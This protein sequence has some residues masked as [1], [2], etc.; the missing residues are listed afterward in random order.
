MFV[1]GFGTCVVQ[2]SDQA[3][4]DVGEA[5]I[6]VILIRQFLSEAKS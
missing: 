3:S 4:Q 5:L 6:F 1:P 2:K